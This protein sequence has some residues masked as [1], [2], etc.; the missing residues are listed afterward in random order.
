MDDIV[1]PKKSD[2]QICELFDIGEAPK[3]FFCTGAIEKAKYS[4]GPYA[5]VT[6]NMC[7]EPTERRWGANGDTFWGKQGQI[8]SK[9]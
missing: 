6:E 8:Y 3:T 5:H 9:G 7:C 4:K 2:F 1:M